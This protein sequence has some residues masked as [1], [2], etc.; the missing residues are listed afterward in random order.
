MRRKGRSA[1]GDEDKHSCPYAVVYNV[2]KPGQKSNFTFLIRG[3]FL[4]FQA[5]STTFSLIHPSPVGIALTRTRTDRRKPYN[6]PVQW[7]SPPFFF[8][9]SFA[10]C[11]FRQNHTNNARR[12]VKENV[13]RLTLFSQYRR[14]I[15]WLWW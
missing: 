3:H 15:S 6:C 13:S 9:L 7:K 12:S 14:V 8:F 5:V 10:L 4:K 2:F 11:F 1:R